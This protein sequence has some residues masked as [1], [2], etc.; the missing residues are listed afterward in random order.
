MTITELQILF[1]KNKDAENAI[2]QEAYLKNQ[3]KFLGLPK[4]KRASLEKQ[5]VKNTKQ[6]EKEQ[7]IEVIF[8]LSELTEREYLYTSQMVLQANYLKFDYD[9]VLELTKITRNNQWWENTDGFQSFL[10]KWFRANPEYIKPFVLEFYQDE[11]M[12]MRRLAIIAQL[13]MKDITDF[14]VMKKAIRYN[15]KYDQFFI[16]KAIGWALRDYSKVNPGDVAAFIDNHREQMSN[17]AIREA[18][19]YID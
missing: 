17:L 1:E 10:K 11:N 9:N 6:L 4:P 5:F 12:W 8:N 14:T 19:K 13:G 16:Q 18:S 2:K 15:L 3:F 7:V